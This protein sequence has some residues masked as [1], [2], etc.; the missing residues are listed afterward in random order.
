MAQALSLAAVH[1]DWMGRNFLLPAE[2]MANGIKSPEQASLFQLV[3]EIREDNTLK[4][5]VRWTDTVKIRDGVL[6]RAPQQMLSYAARY[7]VSENQ[8]TDRLTDMIS[9]V[10]EFYSC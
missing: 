8:V 1:G 3:N 2:R 10:G 9:T 4:Q 7:T 5:S 6:N